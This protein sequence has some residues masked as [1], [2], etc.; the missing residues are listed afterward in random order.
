MVT[1]IAVCS[2]VKCVDTWS[3]SAYLH[4]TGVCIHLCDLKA[5]VNTE[6]NVRM[7]AIDMTMLCLTSREKYI[8]DILRRKTI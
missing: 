1:F 6:T 3:V 4:R 8:P 2:A 5:I 7:L